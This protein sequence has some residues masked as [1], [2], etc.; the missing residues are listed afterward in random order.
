MVFRKVADEFILVP[1]RRK[2]GDL[3]SIYAMDEV[4]GRIWE[5]ID[6]QRRV[7][8]IRDAIVEEFEVGVERA[9]KDLVAL[10]RQLEEISA[11]QV[12]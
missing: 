6:G 9:E 3:Q 12:V 8:D 2:T 5:L 4:A 11:V 10:L 7:G 1:I